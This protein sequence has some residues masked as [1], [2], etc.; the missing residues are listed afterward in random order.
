MNWQD[1]LAMN[2]YGGFVWGSFGA[3]FALM[4]G[5]VLAL[6]QRSRSAQRLIDRAAEGTS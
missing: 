1:W 6:R 4:A 2:G 5:E 3:C